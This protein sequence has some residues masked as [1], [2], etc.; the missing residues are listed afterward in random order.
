MGNK[1]NRICL[2]F[3]K[4]R[5]HKIQMIAMCHEPAQIINTARMSCDTIHL[6]TYKE[7]D[8]IKN[9]NEIYKCEQRFLEII[10]DLNDS[11]YNYTAGTFIELR[12]GMIKY[13]MKEKNFI[14]IDRNRTMIYDSRVG[15]L[16]LKALSL[17]EK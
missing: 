6:T 17:K 8:L 10:N 5:Y 13:N 11:Y 2:L 15:F 7:A 4:G 1:L 14:V 3:L 9:L 16:D 12:Y